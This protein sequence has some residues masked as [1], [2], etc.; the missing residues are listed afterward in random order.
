MGCN[1]VDGCADQPTDY[2]SEGAV[3]FYFS[4]VGSKS[5]TVP[6]IFA[7]N[8]NGYVYSGG[9]GDALA[10]VKTPSDDYSLDF[11]GAGCDP[12]ICGSF[13][14]STHYS[15]F[16]NYVYA[17]SISGAG[18]GLGEPG[19]F[20]E[21]SAD[22]NV[23]I[24]PTFADAGDFKLEFSTFPTSIVSEPGSLLMLGT[25]LLAL[26]GFSRKRLMA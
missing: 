3:T 4:V 11:S 2:P 1:G 8:G 19:D 5:E 23:Q 26:F 12:A 22:L 7:G 20:L 16:P 25:A 10:S 21:F 6:L 17:A 14:F 15:A 13:S 24:D 9:F 18:T